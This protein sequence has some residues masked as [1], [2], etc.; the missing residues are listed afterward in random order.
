M[1]SKLAEAQSATVDAL[2]D[3]IDVEDWAFAFLH[4]EFSEHDP[5]LCFLRGFL[6]VRGEQGPEKAPYSMSDNSLEEVLQQL[7]SVYAQSGNAFRRLD[8]T[9]KNEG[10]YR[11][12]F[13]DTPSLI[14][15][16]KPDPE[17]QAQLSARFEELAARI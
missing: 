15:Q 13:N 5:P 2:F 3:L 11:F 6:V 7:F 16:G 10:G 17:G 8:L 12:E 1:F 4:A 14:L 9:I